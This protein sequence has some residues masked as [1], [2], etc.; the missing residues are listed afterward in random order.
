[1]ADAA[2]AS[3]GGGP[4]DV[5]AEMLRTL[6]YANAYATPPSARLCAEPVVVACGG[7]ERTARL[8]DGAERGTQSVEV[9]VCCDDPT[10]AEATARAAERDLRGADWAG[11][12][13]WEW[14][15]IAV[16]SGGCRPVGRDGSGRWLWA[17]E[18]VLTIEREIDG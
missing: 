11:I 1:M 3:A 4:A 2:F 13:G 10:D 16:D 18:L 6:G 8:V 12:S 17:F 5:V 7:W 15:V 14:R 9:L